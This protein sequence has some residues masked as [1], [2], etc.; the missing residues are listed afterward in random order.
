MD[1]DKKDIIWSYFSQI[2]QFAASIIILPIVLIRLSEFDISMYYI[3]TS[4]GLFINL[5]DFGLQPTLSRFVSYIYSGAQ[6]LIREGFVGSETNSVNYRLL[7]ELVVSVKRIYGFLTISILLILGT[8]GT[9]YI[10]SL[11]SQD[12]RTTMIAWIL[13]LISACFNL[14]YYYY[15]PLLIGRGLIKESHKTIVFSKLSYILIAYIGVALGYGLIAISLAN[16]IGS[17]VNRF[18]SHIMFFDEETKRKFQAIDVRVRVKETLS[19]IGHSSIRMGL[20]SL[21]TFLTYRSNIFFASKYLS[22]EQV[23]SYGLSIQIVTLLVKIATLFFNTMLPKFNNLRFLEKKDEYKRL[24]IMSW[25]IMVIT[26]LSGATVIVLFGNRILEIIGSNALLLSDE[27]L[28]FMLLTF[29]LEI[30]HGISMSFLSTNNIIEYHRSSIFTGIATV[31][32]AFISLEYLNLNVYGLLI[33]QFISSLAYN[34]WK[35]PLEVKK[36]LSSNY[37]EYIKTFVD[38]S[39]HELRKVRKNA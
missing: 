3:F 7:K 13:Y 30:N 10:S 8:L 39:K 4:I 6:T 21:G 37:Y 36:L 38:I 31:V 33:A 11:A 23:A 19:I 1:I 17:F 22:I 9:F 32:I 2:L 29:L 16:L 24:F 26:Y 5:V 20:V 35:W 18:L 15:T 14:F 27:L 28:L 12:Y 25:G 34:N